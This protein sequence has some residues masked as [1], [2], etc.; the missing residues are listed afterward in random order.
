MELMKENDPKNINKSGV[1]DFDQFMITLFVKYRI[2]VSRAKE[3]VIN[4]FAACDLGNLAHFIVID[5]NGMCNFEEWYLL[6][7]HIEPDRLTH[8]QVSEIFFA[9]A[10]LFVEGE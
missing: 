9:N 7:R 4:A 6:L 3:Y 1:I 10:D 5:G 2:L 8:E